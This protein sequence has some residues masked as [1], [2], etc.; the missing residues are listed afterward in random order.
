MKDRY[1]T[2]L[3]VRINQN[4][5]EAIT[6]ICEAA[7]ISQSVYFRSRLADCVMKDA[8][9]LDQVKQDFLYH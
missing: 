1:T 7:K 6:K 9:N 8:D 2:N 4:L 5:D 3:S